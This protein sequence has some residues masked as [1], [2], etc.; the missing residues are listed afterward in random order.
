MHQ[1]P[2]KLQGRR[3]DR[4]VDFDDLQ[5]EGVGRAYRAAPPKAR[6]SALRDDSPRA[7]ARSGR[8][9]PSR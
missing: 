1:S 5:D 9:P 7:Q 6:K 2:V 4:Q 3:R 8:E